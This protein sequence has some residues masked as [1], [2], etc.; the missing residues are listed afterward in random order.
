MV[1][2]KSEKGVA[3]FLLIRRGHEGGEVLCRVE[4][5]ILRNE[6]VLDSTLLY[7]MRRVSADCI[8]A[9]QALVVSGDVDAASVMS[10]LR[11]MSLMIDGSQPSPMPAYEW[12][13]DGMVRHSCLSDSLKGISTVIMEWN[14][15]RTPVEYTNTVQSIHN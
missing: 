6:D 1:E 14:A 15:P 8:P 7:L 2:N 5:K 13:G 10:R 4:D 9:D 12:K 3:D 11:Y